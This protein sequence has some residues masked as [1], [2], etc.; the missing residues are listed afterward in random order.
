MWEAVTALDYLEINPAIASM[1]GE[2]IFI[3]EF[4][5]D[6]GYFDSHI[7]RTVH[8]CHEIKVGDVEACKFRISTGQDT[9]DNQLDEIE[10][11]SWG[12]HVAGVADAVAS[13]RDASAVWVLL[14]LSHFTDHFGIYDFTSTVEWDV[15]V[16]N[17][18]KRVC[19]LGALLS[20]AFGS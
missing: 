12:A 3:D 1:I 20:R 2:V 11:S 15:L 17:D 6:V 9:V 14:L 5:W 16:I 4:L 13:N 8:W 19:P 18:V 7:L 10:P